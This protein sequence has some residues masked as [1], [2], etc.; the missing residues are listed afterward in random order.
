MLV[1]E[2][3]YTEDSI[4]N[5]VGIEINLLSSD[6]VSCAAVMNCVK[7]SK[8]NPIGKSNLNSLFDTRK[9]IVEQYDGEPDMRE[10]DYQD[11]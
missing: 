9:Y 3:D 4:D 1:K 5:L 8:G 10:H 7:D 11:R 2:E 6:G